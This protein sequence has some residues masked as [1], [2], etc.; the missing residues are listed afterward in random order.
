MLVGDIFEAGFSC[1]IFHSVWLIF[2]AGSVGIVA[3][4]TDGNICSFTPYFDL[5]KLRLADVRRSKVHICTIH[6][7]VVLIDAV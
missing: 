5:W 2:V 3:V 6:Y 1:C 4:D 7:L